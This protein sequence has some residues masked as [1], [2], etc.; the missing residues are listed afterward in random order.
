MKRHLTKIIM[1][2]NTIS[3]ILNFIDP[4]ILFSGDLQDQQ[5][6]L[7][8]YFLDHILQAYLPDYL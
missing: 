3:V 2:R 6:V 1:R 7:P 4:K 5:R 8:Y